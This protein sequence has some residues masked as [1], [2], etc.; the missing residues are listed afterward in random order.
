MSHNQ[1]GN[2]AAWLD[3]ATKPLRVATADMPK[4]GAD[5]LVVRVFAAAVNPVDWK[6]Q[7]YGVFVQKWPT[8]LGC[9]IAGEVVEAGGNVQRFKKGDRVTAHCTSLATGD[10]QDG[11]FQHFA[12]VPSQTSAHLPAS[13]T[14]AQ[15]SV[16]PLAVD[17]ALVGLCSPAAESKGLGLPLPSLNP[18]PAN[19]TLVVWGGSSSVGALATQLATAAGAKVITTASSHNFDF[20]RACGAV[21]VVDYKSASVVDDVVAAV[22]KAGGDFVGVYDAISAPDQ[23]FKATVP[24]L[25]KLGGGVLSVVLGP[26]EKVP[27]S[28]K[29]AKVFGINP[30][31]HPVWEKYL[32]PALEQGKL[33]AVPEPLV[34]GKGLES[35]QKGLLKNKEGVSA[36]KVVIELA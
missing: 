9:D 33:K 12:R 27:D 26:P 2:Q 29:V 17:T 32:T 28:V 36:K 31:T 21:D 4:P 13:L 19:K 20:C 35:V 15:G 24:I 10:P 23:S 18:S 34:V 22:Q 6:I 30:V 3:G 11:G 16:L 1:P 25:E 7:D 8:V 5:D 14:Y